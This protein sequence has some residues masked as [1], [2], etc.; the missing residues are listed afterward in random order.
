MFAFFAQCKRPAPIKENKTLVME[1]LLRRS[2]VICHDCIRK[3]EISISLYFGT[4]PSTI[5]G[6]TYPKPLIGIQKG[7]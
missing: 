4:T 2:I 3:Q 7:S 5:G 6:M 1:D